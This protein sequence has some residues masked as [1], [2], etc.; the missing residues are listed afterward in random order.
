MPQP[1]VAGKHARFTWQIYAKKTP[2]T[3]YTANSATS[4]RDGSV[5]VSATVF[6]GPVLS[7]RCLGPIL[8]TWFSAG[9][10]RVRQRE[11][12]GEAAEKE[13]HVF[14]HSGRRATARPRNIEQHVL[15]VTTNRFPRTR[16]QALK[17]RCL[18]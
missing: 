9:Q 3:Q 11:S 12:P 13:G 18:N 7:L 1:P 4:P 15:I 17:N 8:S 6:S 5:L 16:S 14:V 10:K 2:A